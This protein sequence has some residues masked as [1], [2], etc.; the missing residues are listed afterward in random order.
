MLLW[1]HENLR[2]FSDRLVNDED[3]KWF[4]DLLRN[5]ISKEFK[6]DPGKVIGEEMLFFGDFMGT[7]REYEQ[8]TN[9]KKARIHFSC[10]FSFDLLL[11]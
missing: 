5:T 2:V 1:Y 7:S 6:C 10:L 11:V 9:M 4:D 8:I 3:R